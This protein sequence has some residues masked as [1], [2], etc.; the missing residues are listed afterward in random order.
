MTASNVISASAGAAG[1]SSAAAMLV[2]GIPLGALAAALI[3]AGLSYVARPREPDQVIPAR[4]LGILSDAMIGGW[5]AVALIHFTLLH[6]YGVDMIPVEAIAGL[7]AIFWRALRLWIPK[8][9]DQAFDA[10]LGFW[11]RRRGGGGAP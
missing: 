10:F 2:L 7:L 11:T 4:L 8:K 3:G 9:A 5:L 1:A 6:R